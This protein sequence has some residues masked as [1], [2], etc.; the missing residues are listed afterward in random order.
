MATLLSPLPPSPL[1]TMLLREGASSLVRS[2]ARALRSHMG[3]EYVF[4]A[5]L[6]P[7]KSGQESLRALS[8]ISKFQ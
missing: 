7:H 1:A 4:F 6:L 2:P 8:L 3:L 5:V